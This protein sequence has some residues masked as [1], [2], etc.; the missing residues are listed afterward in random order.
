MIV[1]CKKGG[2]DVIAAASMFQ[3]FCRQVSLTHAVPLDM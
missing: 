3:F 2:I 1:S